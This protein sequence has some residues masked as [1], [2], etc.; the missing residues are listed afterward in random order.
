M[1]NKCFALQR[2]VKRCLRALAR[3]RLTNAEQ[4]QFISERSSGGSF[5]GSFL[6]G[7]RNEHKNKN[8]TKYKKTAYAAFTLA[9]V[10]VTLSIVGVIAVLTVPG[11]LKAYRP[12][13]IP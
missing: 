10:L 1:N 5:F 4:L 12:P 11:A 13:V 3:V 6:V 9:E 2:H 7:T 8:L